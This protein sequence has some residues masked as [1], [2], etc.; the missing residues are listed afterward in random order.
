MRILLIIPNLGQGGAQKVFRDQVRFYARHFDVKGCVF[1]W[2]NAFPEDRQLNLSS[3]DVPA[4]KDTLRKMYYF[5]RRIY[6]VRKLKRQFNPA[7]SISHLEGADYVNILSRHHERIFCWIHGTKKFDAN[8]DGIMGGIR[9]KLLIP[10][11]YKRSDLLISVSEGIRK[12]LA[13]DFNLAHT[14]GVTIVNS[15]DSKAIE[16]ASQRSDPAGFIGILDNYPIVITHCR[17]A[18]QKNLGALLTIFSLLKTAPHPKLVILGDGELKQQ[19]L[20]QCMLLTLNAYDA[21]K[22]M[23]WN[24]QYDVY[25]LGN[26]S[27][28]YP[29]LAKAT[30]YVMTSSWEGFPLALCE[31]MACNIPVIASDCHTGPR[32]IIG[33][34]LTTKETIAE[35]YLSAYGMLMPLAESKKQI[36]I[37]ASTIDRLLEDADLRRRLSAGGKKRMLDFD[38]KKMEDR[39]LT[40]VS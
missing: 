36:E 32:E 31:A 5:L 37:W 24:S 10:F 9:K 11:L 20:H 35:P 38:R 28:P 17:L 3:L 33:P 25:F 16:S 19:L 40:I 2:D 22:G 21:G 26:Q 34:E 8:I 30:L 13:D 29:Y 12:E 4:G 18:T 14:P 7:I 23:E 15:I 6:R 39:W 27:N 1:N